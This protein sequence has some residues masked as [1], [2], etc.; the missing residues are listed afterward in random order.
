MIRNNIKLVEILSKYCNVNEED[1]L[2]ENAL[3]MCL[4]NSNIELLN[5]LIL[6]GVNC[7]K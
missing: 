3:H 4:L 7:N 2:G 6:K 5:L 1:N